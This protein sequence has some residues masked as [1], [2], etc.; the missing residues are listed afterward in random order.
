MPSTAMSLPALLHLPQ[1]ADPDLGG[2]RKFLHQNACQLRRGA[3]VLIS[4]EVQAGEARRGG[5]VVAGT[6]PPATVRK[7]LRGD[8]CAY[9]LPEVDWD[10]L[11]K[12]AMEPPKDDAPEEGVAPEEADEEKTEYE[13]L[14]PL[15]IGQWRKRD[16]DEDP[17]FLMGEI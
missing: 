16:D 11:M 12:N 3:E 7:K 10:A 1:L 2:I 13:T 4:A 14:P 5:E 8:V 9:S 6:R 15:T 17:D